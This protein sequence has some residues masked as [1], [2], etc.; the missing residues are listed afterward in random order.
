MTGPEHYREAEQLLGARRSGES[1]A[2]AASRLAEAQIHATLALAA[3]TAL[4]QS[5]GDDGHRAWQRATGEL[6]EPEPHRPR[7]RPQP[8]PYDTDIEVGPPKTSG[9]RRSRDYDPDTDM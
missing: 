6:P 7:Q 8:V 9:P 4:A 5:A 1:A 2:E 3:A